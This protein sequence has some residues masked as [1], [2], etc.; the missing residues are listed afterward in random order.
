VHEI[1]RTLE[2]AA[3]GAP[4][5]LP[6]SQVMLHALLKSSMALEIDATGGWWG[7]P[8]GARMI[9]SRRLCRLTVTLVC[10]YSMHVLLLACD[11]VLSSGL[12]D[13]DVCVRSQPPHIPSP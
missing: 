9:G 7:L 1:S 3:D 12:N 11:L 8:Y 4:S 6:L 10:G 2:A 5:V 13:E